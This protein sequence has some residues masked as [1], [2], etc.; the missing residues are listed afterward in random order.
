MISIF[1]HIV[2]LACVKNFVNNNIMWME[3]ENADSTIA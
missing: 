3:I 1:V 2:I